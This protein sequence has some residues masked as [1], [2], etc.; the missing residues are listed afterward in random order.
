MFLLSTG[1]NVL[2][3]RALITL[4]LFAFKPCLVTCTGRV[5]LILSCC[6]S[7]LT[8]FRPKR[9]VLP[10]ARNMLYSLFGFFGQAFAQNF[11]ITNELLMRIEC[12]RSP[13][14]R[15]PDR[16]CRIG[17]H[18]LPAQSGMRYPSPEIRFTD[19][20]GFFGQS[21]AQNFQITNELLMRIELTTSSL[22]RKCSTPE[23]QQL[24][25]PL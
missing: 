15:H 22:P 17:T 20:W 6:Q 12:R 18:D 4:I 19:Y 25:K 8:T 10:F 7:G 13:A 14:C 23:L 1:C 11:Q 16:L 9:D 21:F 24:V 2:P 3:I 5:V